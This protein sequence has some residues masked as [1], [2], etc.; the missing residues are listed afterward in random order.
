MSVYFD[1][2]CNLS[3]MAG[4][5]SWEMNHAHGD[6]NVK[7]RMYARLREWEK[8]LSDVF[9]PEQMPAPYILVLRFVHL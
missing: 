8:H 1:E 7:Q 2:A 6:D 4:D 9:N 5:I 3:Y